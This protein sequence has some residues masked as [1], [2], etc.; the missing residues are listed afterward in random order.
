[1][2]RINRY[3]TREKANEGIK[4]KLIDPSTG[5]V[6]EDWVEVVSSLS[7]AFREA[8]DKALQNAGETAGLGDEAKRKDAIAEV[9]AKMHAALVKSWSF[10]E[11]CTPEAVREFLREAPQVADAVVSVADDHSRFFGNGLS[12]SKSGPKG[13]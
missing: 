4:V 6:G 11:P 13:K 12:G 1:M 8:R 3:K 7:D 9:K 10:D 5:R 2:S